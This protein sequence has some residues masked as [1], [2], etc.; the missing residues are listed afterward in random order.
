MTSRIW[1]SRRLR[2]WGSVGVIGS[3]HPS[4]AFGTFS[5]P[6]RGEGRSTHASRE[7]PS[8]RLRGEGGRRPGEGSCQI[9]D[10]MAERRRHVK[11]ITLAGCSGGG[12]RRG[13]GIAGRDVVQPR[14]EGIEQLLA[15]LGR[16]LF[17]RKF[18]YVR[19]PGAKAQTGVAEEHLD[20]H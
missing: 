15:I 10:M 3:R 14:Q 13:L 1:R 17:L 18:L 7:C 12:R 4:S 16:G 8:P 20:E 5:P 19:L 6:R 2:A 9:F 11:K